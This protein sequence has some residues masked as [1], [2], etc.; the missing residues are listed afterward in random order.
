MIIQVDAV[1]HTGTYRWSNTA[2]SKQPHTTHYLVPGTIKILYRTLTTGMK[3]EKSKGKKWNVLQ[4]GRNDKEQAG[5]NDNE[6]ASSAA[7]S[8]TTSAIKEESSRSRIACSK[9]AWQWMNS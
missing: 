5:R 1:E 9:K 8:N 4:G 7:T 3:N 6:Q 2:S